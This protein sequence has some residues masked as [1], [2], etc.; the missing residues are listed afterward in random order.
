MNKGK[1][2]FGSNTHSHEITQEHKRE[3][4]VDGAGSESE[5]E[6]ESPYVVQFPSHAVNH[7]NVEGPT[8]EG[9]RQQWV[10]LYCKGTPPSERSYH[11]SDVV[12]NCLYVTGGTNGETVM[13]QLYKLDLSMFSSPHFFRSSIIIQVTNLIDQ[14]SVI[15][16]VAAGGE[17]IISCPSLWPYMH[18]SW[19]ATVSVWWTK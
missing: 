12:N 6:E 8:L 19:K 9:R 2:K 13:R 3:L 17:G 5:E 18:C 1:R 16:M 7:F 15:H 11:D 4:V 10:H 14:P